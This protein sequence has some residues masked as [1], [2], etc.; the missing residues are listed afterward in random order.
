MARRSAP[1]HGAVAMARP[2]TVCRRI[3]RILAQDGRPMP[4]HWRQRAAYGIGV[5]PLALAT[6]ISVAGAAPPNKAAVDQQREPHTPIAIDPKLLDAYAGFYRN[7]AT[8]SI[9]IVTRD[10]DHLLTGRAG[11]P[12]VPEYPVHRPRL[13]SDGRSAAK[14]F[15]HRRLGRGGARGASPDG[16]DRNAGA[17]E[18][19]GRPTR[20]GGVH[21]TS[22]SPAGAPRRGRHQS[23]IA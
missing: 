1:V 22:G 12:R 8:G 14:Q 7:A 9:M 10:G 20:S 13:L 3:E 15:R 6:A 19:R 4:A 18:H 16:T 2:S 11:N 17:A 23:A 5:A 21:A